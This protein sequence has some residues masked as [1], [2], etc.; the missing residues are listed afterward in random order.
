MN[1]LRRYMVLIAGTF[2]AVWTQIV[3]WLT[4]WQYPFLAKIALPMVVLCASTIIFLA[5]ELRRSSAR[6]RRLV[7]LSVELKQKEWMLEQLATTDPLTGL[8]N[9]RF[10]YEQL[11]H[12]FRRSSR[13]GHPLS[14]ILIDL[15]FFKKVNDQ[16]GH[17]VG[18]FVLAEFAD[19]VRSSLRDGDLG[20]R[21]GGEEFIVMLPETSL[22]DAKLVAERIRGRVR[23]RLFSTGKSSLHMSASLGAAAVPSAGIAGEDDLVNAADAALYRAKRDGRDRVVLADSSRHERGAAA[24]A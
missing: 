24:S 22:G 21:Y 9:R 11:G 2:L 20:A 12:E 13:Q 15:D 3:A 23:E 8:Y 6:E 14:V 4:D 16:H 5:Q 19:I 10:F 17:G 7:Q 1:N 18:D